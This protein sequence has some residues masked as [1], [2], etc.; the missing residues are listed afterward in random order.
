MLPQLGVGHLGQACDARLRTDGGIVLV[1]VRLGGLGRQVGEDHGGAKGFWEP[2]LTAGKAV[3]TT[4]STKTFVWRVPAVSR[5][6]YRIEERPRELRHLALVHDDPLPGDSGT[7]NRC[8][9][10]AAQRGAQPPDRSGPARMM[11][12]GRRGAAGVAGLGSRRESS[13]GERL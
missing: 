11:H 8:R 10:P 2:S 12:R 5:Y 3:Q 6:G 4:R 1:D 9:D 7:S 13:F